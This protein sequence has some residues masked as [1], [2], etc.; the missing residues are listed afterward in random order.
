[1]IVDNFTQT[2]LPLVDQWFK[3]QIQRL[4]LQNQA[5][6][7]EEEERELKKQFSAIMKEQRVLKFEAT[8]CIVELKEGEPAPTV[9]SWELFYKYIMDNNAFELLQKRVSPVAVREHWEAGEH[10]PGVDKF[11]VDK[12]SVQRISR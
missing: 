8:D 7:I 10:I 1:V 12:I 11:P 3:K 5:A 9:R 6:A 2:L 4:D